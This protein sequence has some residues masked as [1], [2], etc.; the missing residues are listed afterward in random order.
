MPLI[1]SRAN[2]CAITEQ[3]LMLHKSKHNTMFAEAKALKTI[4][5]QQKK[6]DAC[7]QHSGTHHSLANWRSA[8]RGPAMEGTE[9]RIDLEQATSNN[10]QVE[11]SLL[12]YEPP[13]KPKR[14]EYVFCR[15]SH[16]N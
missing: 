1:F 4:E 13:T 7:K 3:Q 8:Y 15:M 14:S 9:I 10:E 16:D 11:L 12:H 2:C 6:S 5:Q